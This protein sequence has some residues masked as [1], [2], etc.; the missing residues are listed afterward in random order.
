MSAEELNLS[1]QNKGSVV[2]ITKTEVISEG[3]TTSLPKDG[4]DGEQVGSYYYK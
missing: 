2:K 1:E 4:K 3:G